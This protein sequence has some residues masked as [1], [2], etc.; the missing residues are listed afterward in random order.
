MTRYPVK[1]DVRSE[2]II[3]YTGDDTTGSPAEI[4]YRTTTKNYGESYYRDSRVRI[5][6]SNNA[7]GEYGNL[8]LG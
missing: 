3:H 2:N 7:Q 1:E 4:L 6:G 5:L 8:S